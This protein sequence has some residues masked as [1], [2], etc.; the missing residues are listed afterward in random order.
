MPER[1][2]FKSL[3][4]ILMPDERNLV[5]ERKDHQTGEYRRVEIDDLH[6]AIGEAKLNS[7]VPDEVHDQ[8]NLSKNL[9][10]YGWYV[11]DFGM[12]ASLYG[13][14]AVETALKLKYQQV[15]KKPPERSGLKRLFRWAIENGL[16]KDGRYRH[17]PLKGDKYWDQYL[18]LDRPHLLDPNGTEYAAGKLLDAMPS[19]RND[20]GHGS[21]M[22]M[23][24]LANV[25]SLCTC[26]DTINQLFPTD[27]DG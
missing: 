2:P 17:L 13:Y 15:M 8:F 26:A 21:Q 3:D 11:Y 10:L 9:C 7:A 25:A 23:E 16:I 14:I 12:A 27:K 18:E 1:S 6:E 4:Q 22:L 19:L 20:L 5:Y 24:P